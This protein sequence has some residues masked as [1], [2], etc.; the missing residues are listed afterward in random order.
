M[1]HNKTVISN[2]QAARDY[3]LEKPLEAGLQLK[4]NEVK[5]LRNGNANLKGSFVSITKGEVFIYNMHITPYKFS[6]DDVDPVRPRKLLLH[7]AQVKHLEV[8]SSQK[9]YA[10]IPTKIYFH[11]GYAKVEIALGR[12][13]KMHDKRVSLKEKQAKREMDRALSHKNK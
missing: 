10:I 6:R 9:G 2:R 3:Y 8:E 1:A 7:S 12:G 11:R 4:G 13:K 5:S